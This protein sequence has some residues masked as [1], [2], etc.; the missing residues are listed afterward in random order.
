MN[1]KSA[2]LLDVTPCSLVCV[3]IVSQELTACTF[4]L[5]YPQ[6]LFMNE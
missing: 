4:R 3:S 6:L 2:V 1:I 5:K